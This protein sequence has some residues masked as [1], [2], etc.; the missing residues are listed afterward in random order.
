MMPAIVFI[1]TPSTIW[2]GGGSLL[3]ILCGSSYRVCDL[4][5]PCSRWTVDSMAIVADALEQHLCL[6]A[7]EDFLRNLTQLVHKLAP[8]LFPSGN[9]WAW[10]CLLLWFNHFSWAVRRKRESKACVNQHS[11]VTPQIFILGKSSGVCYESD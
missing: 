5:L 2:W 8:F 11:P 9:W 1:T 6:E 7:L 10:L 3:Q 4:A